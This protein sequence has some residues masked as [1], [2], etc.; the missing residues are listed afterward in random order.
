MATSL[1][2]NK[3]QY[4]WTIEAVEYAEDLVKCFYQ[5]AYRDWQGLYYDVKTLADLQIHEITDQAFAQLARYEM[6]MPGGSRRTET[7]EFYRICIQDHKILDAI[8]NREDGISFRPLVL[9]IVTHELIHIIRFGKLLKWYEIP[10]GSEA[11]EARV[12]KVTGQILK[13]INMP[14]LEKVLDSYQVYSI[15]RNDLSN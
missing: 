5:M 1:Y 10:S 3:E 14:G 2:F 8:E 12:H 13:N 6:T 9:Y 15:A 7:T 11:E 4:N